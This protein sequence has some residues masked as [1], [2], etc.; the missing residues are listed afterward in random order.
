MSRTSSSHPILTTVVLISFMTSL[1][2]FMTF[3][4][5]TTIHLFVGMAFG[6][7]SWIAIA[8]VQQALV[9]RATIETMRRH[10]RGTLAPS[11][12]S[13]LFKWLVQCRWATLR[14]GSLLVG[15]GIVFSGLCLGVIPPTEHVPYVPRYGAGGTKYFIAAPL[16]NNESLLPHWS[17]QLLHLV[18]HRE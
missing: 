1:S 5:P 3:P 12:I 15:T 7:A 10:P 17:K 8:W 11:L 18:H 2:L 6:L 13:T 9:V 14:F 4:F 16:H